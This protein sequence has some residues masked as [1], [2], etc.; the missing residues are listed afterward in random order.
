ML[1]LL[2]NIIQSQNR[3][4]TKY[5]FPFLLILIIPGCSKNER[6]IEQPL[7]TNLELKAITVDPLLLHV[8][9]NETLLTD[10]LV[11]P[12]G[13]INVPVKYINPR[14]RFRVTDQFSNTMLADT[15]IAYQPGEKNT[16]TFFQTAAGG[17]LVWVGPPVNEPAPPAGKKKISIV[18]ALP[19]PVMPDEVKVI[20]SSPRDD[21]ANVYLPAD[22]FVLKRGNFSPYFLSLAKNKA[23][24]TLLKNI[25]ARDTVANI[26]RTQFAQAIA[27]FSIFYINNI[28]AR[29]D[30]SLSKLY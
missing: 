13:V 24:L 17:K 19:E 1:Q 16:I 10:S 30:A 27:D 21:N 9:A 29:K 20:V 3:A 14:H 26:D 4:I 8:T 7:F 23:K 22:S 25:P 2:F 28:S 5:G 15:S 11:T 6:A 18:Y 12:D